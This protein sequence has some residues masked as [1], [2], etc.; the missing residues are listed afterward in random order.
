MEW[1]VEKEAQHLTALKYTC[2]ANYF[3]FVVDHGTVSDSVLFSWVPRVAYSIFFY[4][5][6]RSFVDDSD[7]RCRSLA[8]LFRLR[9][10]NLAEFHSFYGIHSSNFHLNSF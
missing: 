8:H 5:F 4:V 1:Q 3:I 6:R 10:F 7:S 2:E 9:V